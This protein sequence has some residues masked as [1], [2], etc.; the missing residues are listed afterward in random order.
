M[1]VGDLVVV[2]YTKG[3]ATGWS[4]PPIVGL[5]IGTNASDVSAATTTIRRRTKV[6]VNNNTFWMDN[7]DLEV[8]SEGR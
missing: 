8:I 4:E 6:L 3:R 7:E 5:I 2:T 1:K